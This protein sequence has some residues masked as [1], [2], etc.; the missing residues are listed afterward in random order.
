MSYRVLTVR[1]CV[2]LVM[3]RQVCQFCCLD[4]SLVK[5]KLEFNPVD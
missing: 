5:S 2:E 3:K 1:N 4:I